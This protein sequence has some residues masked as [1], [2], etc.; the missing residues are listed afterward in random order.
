M[1]R[2]ARLIVPGF[3][4]HVFQQ[5][6]N[7]QKVFRDDEDYMSY[8]EWL[9]EAARLYRV[10][11]HA[12]A[13]LDNGV[14]L[15]ATPVDESG[16]ARMMQWIG[17][18]YVPY[19]NKKYQRSGTLWEGRFRTSIVEEDWLARCSRFMEMQPVACGL[20][21]RPEDYVWSS[22]RHHI[23]ISPSPVIR[24]HAVYWNLGN[25]PF[26]REMAYKA[27]FEQFN[28][29]NR[30]LDEILKKGWPLG[31]DAFIKR[32]EKVTERQFRMGKRG[33]PAKSDR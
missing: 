15:L 11:V 10:D 27:F 6:N 20:A 26:A 32:L 2:S 8:L 29:E 12:Y 13:L 5:G 25:T 19:F 7:R 30:K 1:A 3:P 9:K 4:H 18:H 24:D 22:Y 28:V 17:R 21:A 14:H 31:S 16:L 33:R 23:G